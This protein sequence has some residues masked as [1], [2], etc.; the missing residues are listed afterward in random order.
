M[1]DLGL[2]NGR[3]AWLGGSQDAVEGGQLSVQGKELGPAIK[4]SLSRNPKHLSPP[5][6]G[7]AIRFLPSFASSRPREGQRLPQ[8]PSG[9]ESGL[10]AWLLDLV[11]PA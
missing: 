7:K 1:V 6:P 11:A 8:R 5:S 3:A 9:P 10:R 2:G 4:A